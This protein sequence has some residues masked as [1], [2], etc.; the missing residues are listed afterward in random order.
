MV[1]T[2]EGRNVNEVWPKAKDFLLQTFIERP[3]RNG[4]VL[5]APGPVCTT[6][7]N[8][9]E[10]VLFDPIRDC[11]PFFHFFEGLHMIAGRNDVA[12][13]SQFNS[14]IAS[15]SDD[16]KTFHGAY[17]ARWRNWFEMY[18]GGPEDDTDQLLKIVR[19]L[20][21]NPEDRRAV[22]TMWDPV[23]DLEKPNGKDLPCNLLITFKV[24]QGS[25]EMLVC[26]RS[27]DIVWGLYG[28][29]CVH[30]SMLH[31]YMAGM[32]GYPVGSM[33]TV[34]D[35]FHA[36]QENEVWKRCVARLPESSEPETDKIKIPSQDPR[37]R[38][39]SLERGFLDPYTGPVGSVIP[40][41]M[42]SDPEHW[43]A[44]LLRWMQSTEHPELEEPNYYNDFFPYVAQP[45]FMAWL[46][47]K[48]KNIL[49]AL[50]V[51]DLCIASDWR[52]A[53]RE[54]LQRRVK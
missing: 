21:S 26:N 9:C 46:H 22:L 11:N 49:L 52:R 27:N 53:C 54:W 51:L 43:D 33:H 31:E 10:R 40:Y 35:S 39:S 34:S 12:W 17:G 37:D 6:Y 44:D 3:S 5:E 45:I 41:P 25:L 1:Y 36:Y 29:N 4:P 38:V 24:R 47:Y 19:M 15:Y 20:K 23:N 2:L 48:S 32:M 30:M 8:P 14:R 16:G 7:T 18:G 13:L 42:V 50:T 28:A